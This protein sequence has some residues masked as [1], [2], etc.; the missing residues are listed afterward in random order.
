MLVTRLKKIIIVFILLALLGTLYRFYNF[1]D[2][3]NFSSE[4]GLALQTSA[5]YLAHGF[6]FL[7]QKTFLRTTSMGHII[8]SGALYNYSLV[9]LLTFFNYDPVPVTVFFGVVNLVGGLTLFFVATKIF[10]RKVGLLTLFFYL[11]SA[12]MI[13][14][15]MFIW[16]LHYLPITFAL[17]ILSCFLLKKKK[18]SLLHALLLGLYGGIGFNF[19]YFYLFTI[20]ATFVWVAFFSNHK[21]RDLL[22]FVIGAVIGN[23]TMVIFDLRHDFYTLRSLWQYLLDT[24][25]N[26]GQS[27]I[28]L[29]HFFQ[30]WPLVFLFLGVITA[31]LGHK[32]R[33]LA[34]LFCLGYLAM[35][36]KLPLVNFTKPVGMPKDL[37]LSLIDNAAMT[38]AKNY[39]PE[40]FNV[41]SLPDADFRA[42]TLRYLVT[43]RYNRA[44]Q[45]AENYS[46]VDVLYVL[47]ANDF[48]VTP[49][50]PWEVT[51]M[52][53]KKIEKLANIGKSNSLFKLTR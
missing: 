11:T 49:T 28:D 32:S 46:T 13:N 4:Q 10:G 41:T 51:A 44:P 31:K 25:N 47:A 2:R 52:G 1:S 12:M 45:P 48:T 30:F 3:I 53:A 19:E 23:I 42:Y 39:P 7:G 16:I 21:I 8:F 5:D 15:S 34:L 33:W 17:T 40:N 27:Q 6:S 50:S 36:L 18:G 35:N 20:L 22:M 14:H 29:Y 26:P 38:I 37:D 43:Y 9:P 24:I